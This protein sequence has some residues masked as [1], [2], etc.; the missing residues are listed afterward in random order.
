V[1]APVGTTFGEV[2]IVKCL[3]GYAINGSTLVSCQADASWSEQPH[4][5]I[6]GIIFS[7]DEQKCFRQCLREK[8]HLTLALYN[9][10]ENIK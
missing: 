6:K 2:A 9:R 8:I 5:T 4:C 7:I 1:Q 3:E 10:V